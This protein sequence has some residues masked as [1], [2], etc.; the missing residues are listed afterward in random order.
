[1]ST[2]IRRP[3]L[4]DEEVSIDEDSL[5]MHLTGKFQVSAERVRLAIQEAGPSLADVEKE[6]SG[7]PTAQL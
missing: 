2:T 4:G 3:A 7:H 6:L 1:M 5:V